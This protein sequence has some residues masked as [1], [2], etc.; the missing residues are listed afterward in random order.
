MNRSMNRP[1]FSRPLLAAAAACSLFG[2]ATAQAA[3]ATNVMNNI[4]TLADACDI[5][6]IGIDFGVKSAP[7]PA[8]GY[9]A[10]VT[11]N[12]STGNAI[13]GNTA[14]PRAAADSATTGDGTTGNNTLSLVTGVAALDGAVATVLSTVIG[15]LPGV[16]V[17]CTA[18]PTSISLVSSAAGS[19]AFTFPTTLGGVPTGTFT[20]KMAGVGQGATASNTVD[21]SITFAGTPVATTIPGGAALGLPTLFIAPFTAI[22][23]IPGTQ[24]GT[25]V[26]GQYWDGA[27]AT[28]NF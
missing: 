17:A 27:I 26:P 5:V 19:T 8:A 7:I 3:T 1:L 18:T 14:H 6:A 2:T 24:T 16:Y 23:A 11:T 15:A 9:A 20:G 25:V 12:T 10:Q 4:V 22:G 13:T 28:L 21:Y